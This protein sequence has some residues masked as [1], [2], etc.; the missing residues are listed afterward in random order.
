[1]VTRLSERVRR[2]FRDRTRH[3][4]GAFRLLYRFRDEELG[5][6]PLQTPPVRGL[7][8]DQFRSSGAVSF[9]VSFSR[10]SVDVRVRCF[11]TD[12]QSLA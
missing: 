8:D 12:A 2:D 7:G 3:P 5:E 1:M 11:D 10:H 9:A 6:N 4:D